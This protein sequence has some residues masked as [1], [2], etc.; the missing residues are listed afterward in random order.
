MKRTSFIAGCAL[1]L[2]L[3]TCAS[4]QEYTAVVPHLSPT[5]SEVYKN[6]A[7]AI[8][9]A[10]GA[11]AS[12]KV[13]PFA[14]AVWSLENNVADLLVAQIANP[15]PA[16]V[17]ALKV[18]YST[19]DLFQMVFVLYANKDKPVDPA[20][21]QQGNPGNLLVETDS[22]HVDYFPFKAVGS[23]SIDQS[24]Q[25]LAQGRI[26]AFVFA[27][28]STDAALKRL[29]FK[30]VTR[31]FYGQFVTKVGLRKGARGGP[32]D[33]AIS[34]GLE[35]LKANGKWDQLTRQYLQGSSMYIEW[36]P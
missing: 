9:E 19:A 18:D 17:A 1:P 21:L 20:A 34:A 14:Q 25:R 35:K 23:P 26:D 22:A 29:G 32:L 11:K 24:L 13:M 5:T 10:G 33:K 2:L 30:N 12:I 3:A 16:K 36:Q 28:P 27:Q 7:A 6:L 31:Q 4:V 15:F 8:M